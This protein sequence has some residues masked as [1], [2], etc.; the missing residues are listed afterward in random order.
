VLING[1]RGLIGSAF[2]GLARL[3]LERV[4]TGPATWVCVV[5]SK[6][7]KSCGNLLHPLLI[8]K[9]MG[10][11]DGRTGQGREG[12]ADWRSWARW[13]GGG[14][15][16]SPGWRRGIDPQGNHPSGIGGPKRASGPQ[17]IKRQF[18]RA[19]RPSSVQW[20]ADGLHANGKGAPC[21]GARSW[22]TVTGAARPGPLGSP[23]R[24]GGIAGRLPRRAI[25]G[26]AGVHLRGLQHP[27]V[28]TFLRERSQ[29][30][31]R[32]HGSDP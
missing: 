16:G 14:P 27:G 4:A 18:P 8:R 30:G 3:L 32:R 1:A 19:F 20:L 15:V 17:T 13:A 31:L 23:R 22:A 26:A 5:A 11:P 12:L 9:Y 7:P 2:G 6:P 24:R 29:D 10:R 21:I 25:R 28:P